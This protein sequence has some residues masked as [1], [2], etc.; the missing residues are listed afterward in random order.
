[1]ATSVL[2]GGNEFENSSIRAKDAIVRSHDYCY[3]R[4]Q[5]QGGSFRSLRAVMVWGSSGDGDNSESPVVHYADGSAGQLSVWLN[6]AGE[7]AAARLM[8][9]TSEAGN[10]DP[11][12]RVIKPPLRAAGNPIHHGRNEMKMNSISFAAR[13]GPG[14]L[15]EVKRSG[16]T[17]GIGL[18]FETSVF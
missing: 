10:S 14:R 4:R 18:T 5:T 3:C 15:Q 13:L 2:S 17:G 6:C 11:R 1:M 7:L 9:A 12:R 8:D 16:K